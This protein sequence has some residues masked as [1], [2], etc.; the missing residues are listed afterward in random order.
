MMHSISLMPSS[1]GEGARGRGGEVMT[2]YRFFI[3]PD[4]TYAVTTPDDATRAQ[5]WEF[6][7]RRIK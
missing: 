4:A 6:A 1:M 2:Q 5:A 3:P 7:M